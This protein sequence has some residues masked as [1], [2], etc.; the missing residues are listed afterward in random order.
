MTERHKT[1][2]PSRIRIAVIPVAGE[3]TRLRPLTH[4]TPKVLINVA[5]KPILGHIL[6]K[7]E[8]LGIEEVVLIVGH[9]GRLIVDYVRD[10]YSFKIHVVEQEQRLGLGHAVSLVK[11]KV[12]SEPFLIILGDTIFEAD[13]T[14]VLR[15]DISYIGVKEVED[16]RRFGTVAVRDDIISRMVE[17]AENP[18]SNLAMVGI[19]AL[20]NT[21]LLFECLEHLIANDIRTKGE[22]Q[23]TDALQMMVERGEVMKA[24]TIEGWFDCGKAE[25][26]LETNRALLESSSNEVSL[27]GC[28]VIPPVYVARTAG[29][30][31]SIIGPYVTIADNSVV[32]DSV[33]RNS[34]IN[35]S[36]VVRNMLLKESLVGNSA[37]VIG[38]PMRLNVGDSSEIS[39]E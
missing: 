31:N 24:F 1:L 36:A 12:H 28:I 26:V 17:K 29:V 4:T 22:Y 21:P 3:G 27:P 16:P 19:Y 11:E 20:C 37:V 33:I 7:L 23:L 15:G 18:P 32:N 13:F 10:K 2:E 14:D 38:R 8:T 25:T 6:D 9:L 39:F 34:I 30:Q 35:E 5:G